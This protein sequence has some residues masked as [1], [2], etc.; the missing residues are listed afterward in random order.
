MLVESKR[1]LE[2][3]R[4][5][6]KYKLFSILRLI[7][8]DN[9]Q[10][11]NFS[12]IRLALEELGP[13]FIKLG[14]LLSTRHDLL[15]VELINELSKLQ[16]KVKPFDCKI[17]KKIISQELGASCDSL[18]HDF[19]STPLAAASVAQVYSANLKTDKAGEIGKEV[20]IKILRPDLN[21]NVT[22]DLK[23]LKFLVR[24]LIR[25]YPEILR[26]KIDELII[27]LERVLIDEQDLLREAANASQLRRNFINNRWIYIP[28]VYWQ[29]CT[30]KILVLERIHGVSVTDTDE[31]KKRQI[32][33]K[34]LAKRGVELFFVQVFEHCLFHGDMH[35]GNIMV[36]INNP[37][38]PGFYAIDFG[39]MGSLGEEEQYYLAYNLLAFLNRD[40][41]E[42]ARL[43][44]ESNWVDPDTRLDLFESAIRT[45]SEPILEKPISE[46]SFGQLLLRLFEVGKS[47]NMQLQPQLL[48]FKKSL[49]NIEGI[50][51]RLDPDLDLW[52]TARPHIEKWVKARFSL[53]SVISKSRN[54]LPKWIEIFLE[55]PE[56]YHRNLLNNLNKANKEKKQDL[57]LEQSCTNKT[58]KK[59]RLYGGAIILLSFVLGSVNN[60]NDILYF[61][62]Q[63]SSIIVNFIC[64]VLFAVGLKIFFK[65]TDR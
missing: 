2:I 39:I 51:R 14:Q 62:K 6:K 16:D 1:L 11:A 52:S 60:Y 28:K 29:Y 64:L 9:L 3:F 53:M 46:I 17:A 43:H 20:I 15:P 26:F 35:P 59:S 45:V 13:L 44:I 50:A 33:L 25:F 12:N 27:E 30:K 36:N 58:G 19:S 48:V 5:L 24:N 65:K 42:I 31:L 18:F 54:K 47:F 41:R 37:S 32:D 34:L 21:T 8:V 61:Y 38:D 4:V 7:K 22:K 63:N 57:R 49:I 23:V 40:Y 10:S 55:S 56:L